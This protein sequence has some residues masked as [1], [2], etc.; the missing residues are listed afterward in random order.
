MG[1]APAQ[2]VRVLL[3]S[4]WLWMIMC[5]KLGHLDQWKLDAA[6]SFRNS[7][8]MLFQVA[9]PTG[10]RSPLRAASGLLD[11]PVGWS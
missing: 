2:P 3:A 4:D 1:P 7:R 5:L 6:A 10:M 9:V 11:T 8:E